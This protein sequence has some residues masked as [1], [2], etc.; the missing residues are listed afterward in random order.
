M[1]GMQ[2]A[3]GGQILF[4]C[5]KYD[6]TTQVLEQENL[7]K[8]KKDK[9]GLGPLYFSLYLI[10]F[11]VVKLIQKHNIHTLILNVY[12]CQLMFLTAPNEYPN[13]YMFTFTCKYF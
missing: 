6:T 4:L 1:Y 2:G 12:S 11:I 3:N 13:E 9:A 7:F 5:H 8:K 10:S